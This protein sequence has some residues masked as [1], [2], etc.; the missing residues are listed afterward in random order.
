MS[1]DNEFVERPIGGSRRG[2][3]R[4]PQ[5]LSGRLRATADNG[6]AVK[7]DRPPVGV[8]ERLRLQ[9][10]LLRSA[11]QPDGTYLAWCERIEAK[12]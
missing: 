12:P 8:Y 3:K 2:N 7:V 9:G 5:S 6:K 4:D 11:K 10:F 1:D